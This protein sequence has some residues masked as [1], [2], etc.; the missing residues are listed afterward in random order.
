MAFSASIKRH[1]LLLVS[2]I[3]YMLLF[4]CEGETDDNFPD[5]GH[6]FNKALEC[7]NDKYIYSSCDEEH[8]LTQNGELNVPPEYADEYCNGACLTETYLVLD[9]IDDV[10]KY[11]VFYNKATLRDVR[12]TIKCGC[13]YGPKRGDFNVE[14]HMQ[15][16]EAAANNNVINPFYYAFVLIIIVGWNILF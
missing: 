16:D 5:P 13:S 3:I 6:V 9:C 11:F 8:R 10:I 15:A 14:E 7:L 2:T 1:W 4:T 12:E